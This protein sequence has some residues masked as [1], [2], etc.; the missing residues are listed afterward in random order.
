MR[1]KAG[2]NKGASP[3]SRGSYKLKYKG[4]HVEDHPLAVNAEPQMASSRQLSEKSAHQ[5]VELTQAEPTQEM[6]TLIDRAILKRLRHISERR[7]GRRQDEPL[8][9]ALQDTLIIDDLSLR[10]EAGIMAHIT[11]HTLKFPAIEVPLEQFLS[12]ANTAPDLQALVLMVWGMRDAP[13]TL[14][15]YSLYDRTRASREPGRS[16]STAG[17][18]GNAHEDFLQLLY[19]VGSKWRSDLS[20]LNTHGQSISL[21]LP[22][23]PQKLANPDFMGINMGRVVGV[24]EG[25]DVHSISLIAV[26]E[27]G[28]SNASG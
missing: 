27:A 14:S 28:G 11:A 4:E 5:A 26:A 20:F 22:S 7:N 17:V 16:P 13:D 18:I 21:L 3:S 6:V 12:R 23:L 9:L 1:A 10:R 25:I 2:R 19:E 8:P 15:V 24:N